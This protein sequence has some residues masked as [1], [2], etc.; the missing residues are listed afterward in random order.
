MIRR[1][2]SSIDKLPEE[3]RES[4]DDWLRDPGLS[5]TEAAARTNALLEEMGR[6]ERVK[7]RAV[8]RYDLRRRVAAVVAA[9]ADRDLESLRGLAQAI[10]KLS[11]KAQQL[12]ETAQEIL[13]RLEEGEGRR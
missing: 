7:R 4:L 9:E 10:E 12:R 6:P 5:Q 13:E 11:L 3:V 8:S 2:P 1:R